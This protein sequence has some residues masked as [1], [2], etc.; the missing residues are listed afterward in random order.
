MYGCFHS[1]KKMNLSVTNQF[2]PVCYNLS[3]DVFADRP[4]FAGTVT[5]D[6]AENSNDGGPKDEFCLKLHCDDIVIRSAT[7]LDQKLKVAYDRHNQLVT[8]TGHLEGKNP[9]VTI[10]Y[11][12]KVNSVLTYSDFTKGVFKTNYL[13]NREGKASNYIIATH[14][15]P[16]FARLVF[17]CVDELTSKAKIQLSIKTKSSFSCLSNTTQESVE[18]LGEEKV[19]KFAISQPMATSIFGFVVGDLEYIERVVQ[20]KGKT[21]P[22]RVYTQLGDSARGS[23]ALDVASVSI[24]LVESMLQSSFPLDKLDFVAVPFLSDGAMEN[25]GL[26]TIASQYL[27]SD[28]P[29]D[30]VKEVVVHE[31]VHQWMGNLVSFDS[32]DHLWLNESFATWCAYTVLEKMGSPSLWLSHTNKEMVQMKNDDS[33]LGTS[34]IV[35]PR[36]DV[37][38]TQDAFDQHAYQ[39][40]IFLMRMMFSLCPVSSVGEFIARFMFKAV[41]PNDFFLFLQEKCDFP[42]ATIMY[43]WTRTPGFPLLRVSQSDKL[44]VTQ[45]RYVAGETIDKVEENTPYQ[46]PLFLR[47]KDGSTRIKLMT[48]RTIALEDDVEWFNVDNLAICCFQFPLS[49][50]EKFAQADLSPLEESALFQD[51]SHI[52]SQPYHTDDDIIGLMTL[53]DALPE[54]LYA[55]NTGLNILQNLIEGSALEKRTLLEEKLKLWTQSLVGRMCRKVQWDNISALTEQDFKARNS[56][57]QLGASLGTQ[58]CVSVVK[59]L[60]KNLLRGPKHSVPKQLL[61]SVLNNT[62]SRGGQ[63][64]YKE[65]LSL[66]K[67]PG[68]VVDNITGSQADLQ[69]AAVSALGFAQSDQLVSKTLNFVSTNIDSR[70]IELALLG[71]PGDKLWLWFKLNFETWLVKSSKPTLSNVCSIVLEKMVK[72]N[73]VE[74]FVLEKQKKFADMAAI[75]EGA[76]S[77]FDEKVGL[78]RHE[79]ALLK[80]MR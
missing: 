67:S 44:V 63:K 30:H 36:K 33:L 3:I 19:V 11:I 71:I 7:I 46:I 51:L 75:W 16:N 35:C 61:A 54:D 42:I 38:T 17:P 66:C 39:K 25:W 32:W 29:A 9:S 80:W 15:Q 60:Y 26:V 14:C 21:V 20:L 18:E 64:E 73:E 4:N 43:S 2:I 57:L 34:P 52:L 47:L 28:S 12:A 56:L 8:L 62:V 48:D 10:A 23:S 45:E 41:K 76:K 72:S 68:N 40:G 27:L 6:L 70:L 59:K 31:I 53:L 13:D 24:P 69:T 49:W 77:A 79:E 78:N 37:K 55:L 58:G 74:P 22:V 5:I 1:K 50:Y 65:V